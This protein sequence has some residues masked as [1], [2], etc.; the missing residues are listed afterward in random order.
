MHGGYAENAP[1]EFEKPGFRTAF[2]YDG[3]D[4][5]AGAAA[6]H[7][8]CASGGSSSST[9]SGGEEGEGS[10]GRDEERVSDGT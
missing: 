5:M 4:A 2:A 6:R 3:D 1:F 7:G 9:S 8:G 10:S